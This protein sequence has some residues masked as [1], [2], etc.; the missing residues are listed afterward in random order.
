[1]CYYM[2]DVWPLCSVSSVPGSLAVICRTALAGETRVAMT[3][4]ASDGGSV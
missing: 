4:R 1:V 2:L 3:D